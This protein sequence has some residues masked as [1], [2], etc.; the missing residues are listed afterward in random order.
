MQTKGQVG[1]ANKYAKT[2][3]EKR[4]EKKPGGFFKH[5]Q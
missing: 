4:K 3:T 2:K 1:Y 5:R